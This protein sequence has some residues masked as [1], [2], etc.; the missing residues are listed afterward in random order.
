MN[1]E[2]DKNDLWEVKSWTANQIL[3]RNLW[4]SAIEKDQITNL[5]SEI[6]IMKMQ[7]V[8]FPR[9]P[10]G[11]TDVEFHSLNQ[12]SSWKINRIQ[13]VEFKISEKWLFRIS[14]EGLQACSTPQKMNPDDEQVVSS[15]K[16]P[17]KLKSC[18]WNDVQ[19]FWSIVAYQFS[20][21]RLF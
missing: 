8:L 10:D 9:C 1:H 15:W 6:K 13:T 4:K 7:E 16:R 19:I 11:I 14:Y 5:K 2:I 12:R 21:D 3:R 17:S 18:I 20:E